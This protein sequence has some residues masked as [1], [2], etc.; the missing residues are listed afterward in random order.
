MAGKRSKNLY[1]PKS[2]SAFKLSRSRLENFVKCPRCFY[3]DRRLGIE[4]PSGPQFNL[5]LAVDHLLKKEFDI[6]R[7]KKQA[8]PLMKQ[9][10][11]NAIPLAHP[12]LDTWRN[13]FKGI[14]YLDPATN[15]LV[16]GGVDEV[17]QKPDGEL[18]IVDYKATSSEKEVSLD[19]AWK[20]AY[21]RQMEIYQWLFRKNNFKVSKTGYFVYC[22]GLKSEEDFNGQLKFKT[23]ILP[24]VGNDSWVESALLKAHQCLESDTFPECSPKCEMCL[25]RK[26]A[27]ETEKNA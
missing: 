6:Y 22:N 12:D 9:Y 4:A 25:Y 8:H 17:W 10:G 13:A 19:D 21:K 16:F 27:A 5:N 24:Y 14:Q 20:E 15:F 7:A 23:T 26:I 18:I 1:E 3:L 11:I 2:K